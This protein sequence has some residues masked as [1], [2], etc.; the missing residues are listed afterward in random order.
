MDTAGRVDKFK[1]KMAASKKD[2]QILGV[3]GIGAHVTELIHEAALALQVGL[4]VQTLAET[5]HAH[6]TESEILQKAA[7][8]IRQKMN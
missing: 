8:L 7:C 3:T 5:I 1:K 6:P 4:K 2:G